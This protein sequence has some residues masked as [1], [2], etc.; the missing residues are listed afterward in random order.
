MGTVA[1]GSLV[2]GGDPDVR[3]GARVQCLPDT[4]RQRIMILDGAM[5]T[6]IQR[7]RLSEARP[8]RPAFPAIRP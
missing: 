3:R 1:P 7:C 2:R 6:M 5:G 8:P 4:L